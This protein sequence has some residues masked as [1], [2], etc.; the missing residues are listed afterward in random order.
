MT[1]HFQKYKSLLKRCIHPSQPA[2]STKQKEL[3]LPTHSPSKM[4]LTSPYVPSDLGYHIKTLMN[5]IQAS[6]D[7]GLAENTNPQ[8]TPELA[9]A[10]AVFKTCWEGNI[11]QGIEAGTKIPRSGRNSL[12]KVLAKVA[13]SRIEILMGSGGWKDLLGKDLETKIASELQ[14]DWQEA[15]AAL[16]QEAEAKKKAALSEK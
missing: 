2:F 1:P 9:D 15:T 8:R 5:C 13:S 11:W 16:K 7:G 4:N 3:L 10:V 12:R 14:K 6:T